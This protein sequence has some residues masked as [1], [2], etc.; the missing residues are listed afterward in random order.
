MLFKFVILTSFKRLQE[1]RT[2]SNVY[3]LLTGRRSIQTI[4][5]ATLFRLQS[6]YGV[7]KS[8][9]K[10]DFDQ[11]INKLIQHNFLKE[12]EQ[13]LQ[14]TEKANK[15]LEKQKELKVEANLKGHLYH[16]I[17]QPFYLRLLLL[18]QVWTNR[19]MNNRNYF[20]V[21]ENRLVEQWVKQYYSKTEAQVDHYLQ[22]I[23]DE[24]NR[25]LH[26]ISNRQASIF[27]DRLTGYNIYGLSIEQL[28]T[29]NKVLNSD[30]QLH[31]VSVIHNIIHISSNDKQN[32]PQLYKL[33]SDLL[34]TRTLSNSSQ[35]TE[36]LLKYGLSVQNIADKRRL[37]INTIYD[38]IVE[39]ALHHSNFPY[40]KYVT[41]NEEKLILSA[42]EKLKTFRLKEIKRVLP[43][44]INY[45]QIRLILT[46][47][48][49]KG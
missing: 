44:D 19:K 49:Q 41:D 26:T 22:Q 8:L 9:T 12:K 30:I 48:N 31:L 2:M 5:D 18:I 33:F 42:V 4:Q 24:L 36:S 13:F 14:V 25:I 10:K 40:E 35:Q 37:S 7:Y 38:H 43:E 3:H 34:V 28:A 6:Y 47:L 23:Y 39:I 32:F 16:S 29:K 11:F 15:W 21:V 46:K 45:F 1:E 17:Q 27:V 20:P